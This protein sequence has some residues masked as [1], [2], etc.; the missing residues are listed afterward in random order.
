MVMSQ[1]NVEL[2]DGARLATYR[3]GK[4]KTVFFISGLGGTAGF[5]APLIQQQAGQWDMISLDQR[6]IGK[7][8]RGNARVTI[9]QLADD[10]LHVLD[11]HGVENCVMVGHSTGGVI[12]QDLAARHPNRIQAIALSGSWL[13]PHFYIEALFKQ[14]VSLLQTQPEAYQAFGVMMGYTPEWICNNWPAYEQALKNTPCSTESVQVI[15]ERIDALMSFDGSELAPNL[16]M[17]ALVLSARDDAIIPCPL[18]QELFAAL[19]KARISVLESGGHF[20]PVTRL[21]DTVEYLS[22]FMDRLHA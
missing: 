2:P 9:R 16:K 18:Q 13:K 6:G 12:T 10:C 19:P 14:R 17:P 21:K 4:G 7:S 3:Q 8:T 15:Q 22:S 1:L 11:A 5:W 20:F